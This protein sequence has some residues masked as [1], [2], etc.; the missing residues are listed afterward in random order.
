MSGAQN[1]KGTI[2]SWQDRD[3]FITFRDAPPDW[4]F[5]DLAYEQHSCLLG[6][7]FQAD[8]LLRPRLVC[9]DEKN[10]EFVVAFYPDDHAVMPRLLEGFKVGYTIAIFYPVGHVFLDRTAG[11]RVEKTE[12]VLIIPLRLRDVLVMNE[13]AVEFV[14]RNCAARKCHGCG[15]V[16]DKL[17]KCARCELFHYCNRECQT[18]GWDNHKK[19]CKVLKDENVKKML[20]LDYNTFTGGQV[21]FH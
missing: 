6:E 11:F 15:E 5:H 3:H 20:L 4:E 17:D 1:S 19:Y 14:D 7:I 9:R 16:K 21:S 2:Q 10:C 8:T 13:Q 18:K 12:K